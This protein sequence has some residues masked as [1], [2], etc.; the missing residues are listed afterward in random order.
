MNHLPP[1][2]PATLPDTYAVVGMM[3]ETLAG[4]DVALDAR[5][6]T[7]WQRWWARHIGLPLGFHIGSEGWL[8]RSG[9]EIVA[10]L[11]LDFGQTSCHINNIGVAPAARRQGLARHLLAWAEQRTR[12]RGLTALTLAVT[13]TNRPAVTLYETSGYLA[14]HRHVWVGS[15]ATVARLG[16]SPLRLHEA[17][18]EQREAPLRDCFGAALAADEIPALPLLTDQRHAWQRPLATAYTIRGPRLE[19]LGYADIAP[20]AG[21]VALRILATKPGDGATLRD[22]VAACR[23]LLPRGT[24][25]ELDLGSRH[26]DEHAAPILLPAGFRHESRPRMLMV[27]ALPV[28]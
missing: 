10:Y 24:A 20:R 8:L 27:R 1:P 7:P 15:S 9:R 11:Y 26:A 12:A 21:G 19:L 22:L 23:P 13:V 16:P 14:V 18:A 3:M 25:V 4:V 5:T 17:P 28:G 2:S 6:R